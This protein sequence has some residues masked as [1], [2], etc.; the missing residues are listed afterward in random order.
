MRAPTISVITVVRNDAEG[1]LV[2]AR[3][4][5]QQSYPNIEWVVVDGLSSDGTTDYV[6]QLEPDIGRMIIEQDQGIYDAMN[7]GT[8]AARGDWVVFMNADDVFYDRTTV[9][10]YVARLRHNDD[11][12]YSDVQRREDGRLHAYWPPTLYWMGMLFDHQT[13]FVR[14]QLCERLPFDTSL[15]ISGDLDFFARARLA[16]CRFRKLHWLIGS[17]KPFESGASV[18]YFER[19]VERIKTL[20]RHFDHP[21]LVPR[22]RGEFVNACRKGAIDQQTCDALT[23]IL[24]GGA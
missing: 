22:L 21:E 12:V 23:A 16:G 10:E 6:R 8:R 11:I 15:R 19:Q 13:A 14:R 4:V 18:P 17:I 7:K 5:L 3:S 9:A 24:D 1:F 20:T 2:T